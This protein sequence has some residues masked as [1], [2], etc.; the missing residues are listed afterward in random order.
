MK[1]LA[2]LCLLLLCLCPTA[3]ARDGV[4][5]QLSWDYTS[6]LTVGTIVQYFQVQR[7]T[8]DACPNTCT[9]VDMP[10]LV[11]S[12][13]ANANWGSAVASGTWAYDATTK[14]TTFNTVSARYARLVEIAEG[15]GNPW[16]SAVELRFWQGTTQI[17]QSALTVLGAD[18]QE[19]QG[20]NGGAWNV[21]DGLGT[22]WITQWFT[23]SPPPPHEIIIDL[24][25]VRALSRL[26][27]VPRQDS[28]PN[29]TIGTY[30]L[31]AQVGLNGGGVGTSV[32]DTAVVGGASYIYQAVA[33][34]IINGAPVRSVASA[35]VCTYVQAQHRGRPGVFGE[36]VAR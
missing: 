2:L 36:D 7:C 34:G 1:R 35:P 4:P 11:P 30:E 6:V 33:V 5:V 31:Y 10:T 24:G 15:G 25:A 8:T 13:G 26:D 12:V 27:Y 22:M 23:A 19:T 18:S 14:T 16:A 32:T 9:P 20:E 21:V 29:G 3:E 28:P 17:A